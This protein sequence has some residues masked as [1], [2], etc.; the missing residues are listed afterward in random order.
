MEGR[1]AKLATRT[2]EKHSTT[3]WDNFS[4]NSTPATLGAPEDLMSSQPAATAHCSLLPPC[5]TWDHYLEYLGH[6]QHS[7]REGSAPRIREGWLGQTFSEPA[8]R[9][10]VQVQVRGTMLRA[11]HCPHCW[12]VASSDS[13]SLCHTVDLL[14]GPPRSKPNLLLGPCLSPLLY[15]SPFLQAAQPTGLCLLRYRGDRGELWA[16]CIQAHKALIPSP[17]PVIHL[18]AV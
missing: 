18:L 1:R 13:L 8:C 5:L 2:L 9:V 15:R 4:R 6:R 3:P 17:N 7:G 14:Q 12:C 10:G 11:P 16:L